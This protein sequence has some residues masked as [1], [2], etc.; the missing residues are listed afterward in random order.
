MTWHDVTWHDTTRHG[1]TQRD[2]TWHDMT[3]HNMTGHDITL[4]SY[5][6]TPN[7]FTIQLYVPVLINLTPP[8]IYITNEAIQ[9]EIG[10]WI[11]ADTFGIC[12]QGQRYY[13]VY[14][15]ELNISAEILEDIIKYLVLKSRDI[16]NRYSK[17]MVTMLD[18]VQAR[19]L[20]TNCRAIFTLFNCHK[21]SPILRDV[22]KIRLGVIIIS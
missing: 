11:K 12:S 9:Q 1:M 16:T 5:R 3:W 6:Y 22:T 13:V 7:A 2:T 18:D 19:H 4:Y 10:S 8:T 17:N 21:Y 15:M 14:D 20:V